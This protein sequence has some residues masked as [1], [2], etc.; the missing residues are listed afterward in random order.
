MANEITVTA[1][2]KVAKGSLAWQQSVNQSI[3]LAAAKPNGSGFSQSIPTTAGGTAISLGAV[4]TNGWA[5]F[6][7]LDA[8][9]YVEIGVADGGTFFPFARLLA[10]E[11]A[12]MRVSASAAPYA[13]ANTGAVI[14][15]TTIFDA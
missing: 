1:T 2:L 3:T 8:T 12:L 7:N 6:Q 10:G 13:L 9:N 4:A 14:L 5:W 15:M 11:I